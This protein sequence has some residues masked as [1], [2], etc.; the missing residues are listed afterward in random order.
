MK[1]LLV[2]SLLLVAVA[3][4]T[5]TVSAQ[6]E[7]PSFCVGAYA[8]VSGQSLN[9]GPITTCY[10]ACGYGYMCVVCHVPSGRCVAW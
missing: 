6:P 3:T 8:D 7:V 1:S 4:F 2:A 9:A 10:V 5:P